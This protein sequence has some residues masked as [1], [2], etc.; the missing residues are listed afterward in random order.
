MN[1][2]VAWRLGI[3]GLVLGCAVLGFWL[4][5]RRVV[6]PALVEPTRH[7]PPAAAPAPAPRPPDTPSA[8]LPPDLLRLAIAKAARVEKIKRDY[9]EVRAK[10]AADYAAAGKSFPGGLNGFLRQL[11]LLEREKRADLAAVLTPLELED[12]ELRESH[13]G[14]TVRSRLGDTAATDEE[15]RAAFRLLWAHEDRFALTFDLSP[16][17]LL[18]RE[19]DR[20]QMNGGLRAALGDA[21]FA[22]WLEGEGAEYSRMAA[23]AARQGL[24]VE[25]GLQ[26]WQVRSDYS[27]RRLELNAATGMSAVQRRAANAA[28]VRQTEIRLIGI[29]GAGSVQLERDGA[30][31]W[32]PRR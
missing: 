20:R 9:D 29:L 5:P 24:P 14:K 18:E 31:Q 7:D 19:T 21:L 16:A 26:L 8:A 27:V 4:A 6:V 30:L 22:R 1:R 11:A 15:I 23:V 13:A 12:L 28:L 3:V 2:S 17:A 25:A 10:A 32:L